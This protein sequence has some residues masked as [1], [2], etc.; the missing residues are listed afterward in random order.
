MNKYMSIKVKPDSKDIRTYRLG[1]G[2]FL[3]HLNYRIEHK[4]FEM[5]LSEIAK[6]SGIQREYAICLRQIQMIL[7]KLVDCL[8]K[9]L[10][11]GHIRRFAD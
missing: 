3:E 11:Y 9:C 2:Y 8:E 1:D 7:Y 6:Y 5:P 10:I 4:N